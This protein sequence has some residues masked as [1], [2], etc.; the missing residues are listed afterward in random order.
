MTMR[1]L[2]KLANVSISTVSKAF[3][4]ADDVS[5][6]TKEHIFALA[7]EHGCFGKYYKGKYHKKIIAI[8]CPELKSNYY[9]GFLERLQSLIEASGGICVISADRFDARRQAELIEY[10]ASYLKVDGLIVFGMR[11]APKKGYTT[12]IVSLLGASDGLVDAV[13]IDLDSAI[14]D[15]IQTL[16]D[17]GHTKI[18]FFSET[19]TTSKADSFRAYAPKGSPILKSFLRFEEAGEACTAELLLKHPDV[20]AIICAYDNIAF[21]AMHALK[22]QGRKVPEDISVIG[23]DNIPLAEHTETTLTSIDC[24]PDEVCRITWDLLQKKLQSPYF[25]ARQSIVIKPGLILRE[26][27]APLC[28]ND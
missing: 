26:S 17:F 2:A 18:A 6:E 19:L 25:R 10:Y 4:D 5:A 27:I 8:I 3:C 20:T 28:N 15:A 24:N 11:A 12:P 23:I 14:R 7:R 22:A 16:R 9:T 21:G 13:C 1:E